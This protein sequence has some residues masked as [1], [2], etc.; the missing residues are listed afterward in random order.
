[1]SPLRYYMDIFL[2]GTGLAE[3]WVQAT[4][5]AVIGVALFVLALSAFR[6]RIA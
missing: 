4:A 3:L 2:K 5:L 1:M 6:R